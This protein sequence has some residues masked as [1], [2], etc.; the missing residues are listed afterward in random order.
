M[1][2]STC[3]SNTRSSY[4][5]HLDT[6]RCYA[7]FMVVFAHIFKIW[8]WQDTTESLFPL[9][10]AGVV[11]FFVLSGF[12][13]TGLLLKEPEH[14]SVV[15]SFWQFYLRRSLRIFPIYYLYLAV[16]YGNNIAGVN[17]YGASLWL[18]LGNFHIFNHDSWM[19]EYSHLWTLAVEEQ[20]YLLWPFLILFLRTRIKPLLV[21]FAC[22]I[23]L[24]TVTRLGLLSG[25]F[26][27]TQAKVF[28]LC[29]VDFFAMGALIALGN[30]YCQQRI[31]S[32]GYPLLGTGLLAYYG[33]YYLFEKPFFYVLG[34]L[35]MGVAATG[36][37]VIALYSQAREGTLHNRLT[38]HLGTI[39]YGIYLYH[40][41]IVAHYA[42][43]AGYLG[44]EAGDS[45]YMKIIIS[46]FF[47][48]IV[49]EVSYRCIEKPC[50][51]LKDRFRS[52]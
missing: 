26:S 27:Y 7:V 36:I 4:F 12:L 3:F 35:S 25:G 28:P 29:N 32:L 30:L 21:L 46:I 48:L 9:G 18:Y 5:I 50:L 51:R 15:Q 19:G 11:L 45:I 13:I 47:T 33:A 10:Q 20:F 43:I 24:A 49:A 34:Q 38:V 39:S 1:K 22:V 16:C 14:K 52:S 42:E 6:V 31:R 44:M 23:A 2:Q 17:D 37:I 8:T 41:S 40:N